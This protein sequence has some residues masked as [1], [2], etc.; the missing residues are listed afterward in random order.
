MGQLIHAVGF[1][2]DRGIAHRDIWENNIMIDD[3]GNAVL[4]D[5]GRSRLV[6]HTLEKYV[7]TSQ[8]V[9]EQYLPTYKRGYADC[10]GLMT[11]AADIWACG[12]IFINIM[13][14]SMYSKLEDIASE[15]VRD[16]ISMMIEEDYES[17]IKPYELLALPYFGT[18]A[19]IPDPPTQ[20]V[21]GRAPFDIVQTLIRMMEGF[22]RWVTKWNNT[23][24]TCLGMSIN[25]YNSCSSIVLLP[26]VRLYRALELS[27][28]YLCHGEEYEEG[29]D[30]VETVKY[31]IIPLIPT[32][33]YQDTWTLDEV[34]ALFLQ[35]N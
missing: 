23:S 6:N 5:F 24:V 34:K 10:T 32:I 12:V 13:C 19:L 22:K 3:S 9:L 16:V 21:I 11:L 18:A 20:H 8:T 2:H 35:L 1:I 25:I 27:V 28:S 26:R 29:T 4:I 17:Y 15:T 30:M 7:C 33:P 31:N 14:Q